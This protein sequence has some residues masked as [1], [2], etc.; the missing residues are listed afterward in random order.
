MKQVLKTLDDVEAVFAYVR[1][2]QLLRAQANGL[3][4]SQISRQLKRI[5]Q[6]SELPILKALEAIKVQLTDFK[7][8][9]PKT[10]KAPIQYK[11]N[12]Y[13]TPRTKVNV[14]KSSEVTR[15]R[16]INTSI[17]PTPVSQPSSLKKN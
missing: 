15:K 10:G 2:A 17:P 8:N 3:S 7:E 16:V 6:Q 1:R 13:S 11:P 14:P 9:D 12:P 4:D 5:I